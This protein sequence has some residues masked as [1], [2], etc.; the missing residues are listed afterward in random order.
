MP[1]CMK[2]GWGQAGVW[3]SP[4]GG[5]QDR[6]YQASKRMM[7]PRHEATRAAYPRN[8]VSTGGHGMS[9]SPLSFK[10]TLGGSSSAPC[11]PLAAWTEE[12]DNRGFAGN[13]QLSLTLT[14][15]PVAP[16]GP[17]MKPAGAGGV[18]FGNVPMW[19]KSSWAS[20][21]NKRRKQS[22][23]QA[24][25]SPGEQQL[26]THQPRMHQQQP[27]SLRSP[28]EQ[29]LLEQFA[30]NRSEP[31]KAWR[32][33]EATPE[34][35]TPVSSRPASSAGSR[36]SGDRRIMEATMMPGV[37]TMNL[38][39]DNKSFAS[40]LTP[41][42]TSSWKGNAACHGIGSVSDAQLQTLPA[43]RTNSSPGVLEAMI[44]SARRK[45]EIYAGN[46][47]KGSKGTMLGA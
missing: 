15:Q 20:E 12:A 39:G 30:P 16:T 5:E 38:S 31:L 14:G 33:S 29:Q 11:L 2:D 21:I 37:N 32:R 9:T 24:T 22:T 25:N 27:I 6:S 10:I 47:H 1:N 26:M 46:V 44:K 18:F 13:S 28:V 8:S 40:F 4:I 17:Q 45:G 43:R 3:N 42:M 34:T 35:L 23:Y 19:A 7:T 36:G 41:S